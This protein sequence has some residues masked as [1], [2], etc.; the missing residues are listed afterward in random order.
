MKSLDVSKNIDIV[1]KLFTLNRDVLFLFM[2]VQIYLTLANIVINKIWQLPNKNPAKFK[3]DWS[4]DQWFCAYMCV[5]LMSVYYGFFI[6]S[7]IFK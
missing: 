5:I 2:T 6:D 3:L 7:L 4:V 1:E